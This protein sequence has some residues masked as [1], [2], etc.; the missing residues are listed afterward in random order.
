MILVFKRFLEQAPEDKDALLFCGLGY[1]MLGEMNVAHT[2]YTRSLEQNERR[3]AVRFWR[4]VDLIAS[5]E[6][7]TR[8]VQAIAYDEMGDGLDA[9]RRGPLLAQS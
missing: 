9:R 7:R 1:Q 5:E 4:T 3:R 2:Y 8:M 6:E